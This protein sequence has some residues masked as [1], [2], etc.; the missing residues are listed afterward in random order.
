[1]N[2]TAFDIAERFIGTA[3]VP[4]SEDNP[5]VLAMLHLDAKWPEGDEV[6]WCSGFVNYIAWLLRLPRS[7]SL[8]A[9]SWLDVGRPLE[10]LGAEVGFDVVILRRGPH[11][12]QSGPENRTAPGHVG[13]YAGQTGS[14][15]YL[16]GGNQG[17]RVSVASYLKDRVLGVRRLH[18]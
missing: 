13:F 7:K 8:L 10:P 5:Q 2:I 15:V 14:L 17:N 6:P 9:R 16:L 18:E 4:G 12:V 11:G 3:E 1:M